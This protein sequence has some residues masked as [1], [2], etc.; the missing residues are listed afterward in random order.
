[1]FIDSAARGIYTE[2][3]LLVSVTEAVRKQLG[4]KF[5]ISMIGS[6]VPL[7]PEAVADMLAVGRLVL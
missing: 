1:M 4:D 7:T 6:Q 2:D 3:T 5:H